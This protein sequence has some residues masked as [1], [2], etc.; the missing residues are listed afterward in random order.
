MIR[1]VLAFA[2]FAI[3]SILAW[4]PRSGA[5]TIDDASTWE[6]S[7]TATAAETSSSHR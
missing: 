2:V 1:L 7:A 6:P 3:L 5:A 4:A